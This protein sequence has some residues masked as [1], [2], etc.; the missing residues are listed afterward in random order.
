MLDS[1]TAGQLLSAV[2]MK[3]G[4]SMSVVV[5]IIITDIMT[6]IVTVFGMAVFHHY[7]RQV[8]NSCVS[9]PRPMT[10]QPT[11]DGHGFLKLSCCSFWWDQQVRS[12]I[13]TFSRLAMQPPSTETAYPSSRCACPLLSHGLG[14]LQISMFT[15]PKLQPLGRPS[16]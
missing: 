10:N 12:S 2:S 5:G 4:G 8:S 16:L 9:M 15:S 11:T 14:Q 6:W 3:S 13:P 7:E 1:I